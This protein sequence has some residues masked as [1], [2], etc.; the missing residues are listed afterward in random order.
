MGYPDK[1]WAMVKLTADQQRMLC[2]AEPAIFRPV[3]GAWGVQGSTN[4]SLP[5]ADAATVRSALTMAW[6]NLT[7]KPRP[8]LRSRAE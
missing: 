6:R 5:T 8:K 3:K 7:A 2:E 4:L 1:A